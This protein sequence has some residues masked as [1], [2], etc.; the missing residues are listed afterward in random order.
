MKRLFCI[1]DSNTWGYDPRSFFGDRYPLSVRWTGILQRNGYD[2]TN[3]GTNGACIPE[4]RDF[5]YLKRALSSFQEEDLCFLLLGS[6]NLLE[7]ESASSAA[8]KMKLLLKEM[9]KAGYSVLLGAPV[10]LTHGTWVSGDAM[11]EE[12]IR[13]CELYDNLAEELQIPFADSR[14]WHVSLCFDG[15]HFSENG[16]HSFAEGLMKVLETIS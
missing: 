5:P 9:K 11:I 6:N 4:E 1:G 10:P 8:G 14:S 13:L 15:V 7:K 3:L 2:V 12:S 16:H